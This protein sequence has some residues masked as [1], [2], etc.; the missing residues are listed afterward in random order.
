V[1]EVD[2]RQ[3]VGLGTQERSPAGVH[4]SRCRAEPP[5]GQDAADRASADVVA[6]PL[7]LTVD[8]AVSPPRVVVCE[9]SDEVADFVVDRWPAGLARVVQWRRSS[10][11][12]QAS[13]VAG[14]TSR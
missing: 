5:G 2:R 10:R 7:Q 14:V 1:E 4:R 13:R 9:A 12:C 3:A 8:P 11:G 6:Q